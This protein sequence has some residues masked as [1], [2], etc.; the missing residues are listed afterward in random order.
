MHSEGDQKS[1]N[2]QHP[3]RIE[4]ISAVSLATH[5]M[6]RAVRVYCSLGFTIPM[7]MNSVSQGRSNAVIPQ[8]MARLRGV[9]LA[10]NA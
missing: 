10:I 5:D 8:K 9:L 7:D 3:S 2:A 6:A 1:T 4:T